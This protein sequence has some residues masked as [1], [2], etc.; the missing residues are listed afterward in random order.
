MSNTITTRNVTSVKQAGSPSLGDLAGAAKAGRNRAVDFYRAVAMLAVALGHWMVI[1][2]YRDTDGSIISGNGLEFV[3]SFSYAT[4]VLQVMPLFFMVGGYASA[5]SLDSK[6]MGRSAT[7]A[8]RSTWIAS[9][10]ARLLPPVAALAGFWLVAL[11]AGAVTGTGALIGAGAVA[12]AIPLWFLANYTA[13]IVLAPHVLPWFRRSPVGTAAVGLGLFAFF[14]GLHIFGPALLDPI[15]MGWVAN[16]AHVNWVIGWFLFQILGFAWRDG[17]LPTGG[18]LL[19]AAAGLWAAAAAAVFFGPWPVSMVHFPGLAFSPT[20]PP[21]LALLLF[22][23]AQSATAIAAAPHVT[24]WLERR[25]NAW[26]AVVAA[27]SMAMSVYLWHMTAGV[28]TL[29]AFDLTGLMTISI[30]T[31]APGSFTWFVAKIPFVVVSMTLLGLAL[32]RLA[33][34]ERDAL[35]SP[36]ADWPDRGWGSTLA[37][38]TGAVVVSIALKTWT[39]GNMAL[40]AISLPVIIMANQALTRILRTRP[41]TC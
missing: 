1:V 19:A 37:L 35:L 36:K 10:L 20:H 3:P 33:R 15:G 16:A 13:D 26:K 14:E 21:S 9:R 11:A 7:Q 25:A 31:A 2:A 39:G 30:F 28:I 5:A 8:E 24:S 27:N 12:A 34:I 4:W 23:A 29:A 17:L 38:I 22:G 40:I 18:R 6:Q 41:A 32:P